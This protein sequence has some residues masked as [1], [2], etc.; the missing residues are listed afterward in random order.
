MSISSW[1]TG[2]GRDLTTMTDPNPRNRLPRE[3]FP[4]RQI[5]G[6]V[7]STLERKSA[8]CRVPNVP[9]YDVPR[10]E[11]QNASAISTGAKLTSTDPCRHTATTHAQRPPPPPTHR[12]HVRA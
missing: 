8:P 4:G 1:S 12:T 7:R 2:R 5:V 11:A 10:R 6:V 9:L 3:E